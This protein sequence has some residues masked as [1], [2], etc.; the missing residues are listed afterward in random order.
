MSKEQIDGWRKCR[1]QAI[2]QAKGIYDQVIAEKRSP[3]DDELLRIEQFKAQAREWSEKIHQYVD[4]VSLRDQLEALNAAFMGED[5]MK[6]DGISAGP[7]AKSFEEN[8][9][10]RYGRKALIEPVG[11]VGVPAVSATLTPLGDDRVESILQLIPFTRLGGT[12]AFTYLRETVRDHRAAPVAVG[13]KKPTSVYTVERI[14]DRTRTIAHLSE[15]IPRQYLSDIPLLRQYVDAVLREGYVLELEYQIVDGPGTGEN[16]TGLLNTE[17]IL[18]QAFD[19]DPLTTTRRAITA[20]ERQNLVPGAY[21]FHPAQWELFE[22]LSSAEGRF[23]L[24]DARDGGRV[25]P[26]DRARRRLWGLPVALSLAMPEGTGLLAD[27]AGSTRRWERE[28]VRV[29]W[30]ESSYNPPTA[31]D[32]TGSS[33]FERNLIRFRAEGREGFAVLRPGGVVAL[34]LASGS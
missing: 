9:H 3:T 17:G 14:E 6:A 34:E 8:V 28:T 18:I 27:F 13:E 21:V 10:R 11:A 29:D 22:L 30:S 16:M 23:L 25:I 20:L 4:D 32:E 5:G 15:P 12:D 31:Y 24:G 26:I 19:T 7:W 2:E 33:D 1:D